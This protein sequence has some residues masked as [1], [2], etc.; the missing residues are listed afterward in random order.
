MRR[1][2]A[3]ICKAADCGKTERIRRSA[4]FVL[5]WLPVHRTHAARLSRGKERA[6]QKAGRRGRL[7]ADGKRPPRLREWL[8]R[9][10]IASALQ[11][12]RGLYADGRRAPRCAGGKGGGQRR[13]P[14]EAFGV[15]TSAGQLRQIRQQIHGLSAVGEEADGLRAGGKGADSAESRSVSSAFPRQQGSSDRFGS[16]SMASAL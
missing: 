9:P 1:S 7:S 15:S 4:V 5:G 12:R 8:R 3:T 6:V 14:V 16:A 11:K 10:P 13:K 2:S